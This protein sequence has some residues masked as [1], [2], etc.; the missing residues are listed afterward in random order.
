MFF[1]IKKTGR[2]SRTVFG[3]RADRQALEWGHGAVDQGELS[4]HFRPEIQFFLDLTLF[5]RHDFSLTGQTGG[6][7]NNNNI[8]TITMQKI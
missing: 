3:T 8:C 6:S 1:Q 2:S 5:F 7:N 4:D